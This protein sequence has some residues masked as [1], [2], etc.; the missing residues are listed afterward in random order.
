MFDIILIRLR[1][2]S[3][4]VHRTVKFSNEGLL[5]SCIQNPVKY[6]RWS[7]LRNSSWSKAAIFEKSSI[8]DVQEGSEYASKL[9]ADH[10]T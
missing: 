2:Y 6:L 4:H 10:R 9:L 8:L 7:F 3:I 1:K 5:S